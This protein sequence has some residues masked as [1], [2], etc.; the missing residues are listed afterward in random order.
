MFWVGYFVGYVNYT[1]C[2][3]AMLLENEGGEIKRLYCKETGSPYLQD[4][5]LF[6]FSAS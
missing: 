3:N 6:S 1:I 5:P 2:V 4:F